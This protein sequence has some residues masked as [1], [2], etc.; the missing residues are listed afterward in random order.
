VTTL[1]AQLDP[2]LVER[3]VEADDLRPFS[4]NL[5][6]P[7]R[8]VRARLHHAVVLGASQERAAAVQVDPFESKL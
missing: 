8:V 2:V 6:R 5:L 1:P 3:A 4:R 7:V